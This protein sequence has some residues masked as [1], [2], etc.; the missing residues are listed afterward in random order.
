MRIS[1]Q[2]VFCSL[3]CLS[4]IDAAYTVFD[5]APEAGVNRKFIVIFAFFESTHFRF[6]RFLSQRRCLSPC[7]RSTAIWRRLAR[8]SWPTARPM[9]IRSAP[10]PSRSCQAATNAWRRASTARVWSSDT[11]TTP[12]CSAWS[13][14]VL[15]P[16]LFGLPFSLRFHRCLLQLAQLWQNGQPVEL[17]APSRWQFSWLWSINDNGLLPCWLVFIGFHCLIGFHWVSFALFVSA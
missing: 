6:L 12:P 5:I 3:L 11:A 17:Q 4:A 14:P 2:I 8:P 7:S 9:C 1:V 16:L 15:C 13:A 10:N